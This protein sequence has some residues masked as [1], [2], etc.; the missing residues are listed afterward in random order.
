M[1]GPVPG[2]LWVV[3]ALIGVFGGNAY[4]NGIASL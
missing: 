1:Y 4:A 2:K 3:A